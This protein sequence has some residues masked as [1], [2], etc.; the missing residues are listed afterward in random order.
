MLPARGQL[1][2]RFPLG[3]H[4]AGGVS[5]ALEPGRKWPLDG[6]SGVGGYGATPG[7]RGVQIHVHWGV[8]GLSNTEQP[9]A[10]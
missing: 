8:L 10:L 1:P 6:G 4:Q 7:G 2:V 9:P 5:L 3:R